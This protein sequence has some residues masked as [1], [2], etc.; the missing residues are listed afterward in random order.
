MFFTEYFGLKVALFLNYVLKKLRKL[1]VD[2][3]LQEKIGLIGTLSLCV[4]G[5]P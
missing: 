5:R 2:E 4:F 1:Y 3:E